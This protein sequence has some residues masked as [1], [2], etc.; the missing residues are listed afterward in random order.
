MDQEKIVFLFF[1]LLQCSAPSPEG[2]LIRFFFREKRDDDVHPSNRFLLITVIKCRIVHLPLSR[3]RF[4]RKVFNSFDFFLE[5]K[6]ILLY[7]TA[8]MVRKLL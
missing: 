8:F 1:P 4:S 3:F 2:F 6:G 5:R 7:R